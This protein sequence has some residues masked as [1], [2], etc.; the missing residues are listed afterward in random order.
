MT[1]KHF[2]D[3]NLILKNNYNYF[4]SFLLLD[5][6]LGWIQDFINHF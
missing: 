3:Q 1:I 5:G 4:D 2:N 6:N